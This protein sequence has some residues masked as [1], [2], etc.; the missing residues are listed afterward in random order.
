MKQKRRLFV[1]SDIHGHYTLL[2]QALDGAGFD[3]NDPAHLFVCCGDLFD[4]GS[5]NRK[6]YDYVCRLKHKILILGN[7]D[8]RLAKVLEEKRTGPYDEKNGG[9]RTL[10]EFFGPYAVDACGRLRLPPDGTLA[11]DL[12]RLLDSMLDY[13]E[14]EHYVFTHGWLP[15]EPDSYQSIIRSDWREAD[16]AAWHRARMQEWQLLYNT[17]TRLPDKTIV[18]GH[19]HTTFAHFFDPE[20]AMNDSG[21][22]YGRGMIAI[23]AGTVRSGRVNVLVLE[24]T[25]PFA[26]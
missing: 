9:A 14:T 6:V 24:E 8:E 7:H 13:Y 10:E 21:I 20:R 3:E 19:R 4:R 23:D 2:K 5:E 18:C 25:V 1:V 17:S 26:K 22:F 12:R 15:L 16:A 11:D